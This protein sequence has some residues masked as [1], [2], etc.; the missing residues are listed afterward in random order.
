MSKKSKSKTTEGEQLSLEQ[1]DITLEKALTRL[2]E[3]VA[4]MDSESID[5]E[6]S[7]EL[8]REGMELTKYCRR[9]ISDAEQKV[10][11]VLEDAEGNLSLEEF[12]NE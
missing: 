7:I 3:I 4:T 12:D 2:G 6:D 1:D 8:F 11:Q 9:L 10:E 5:L